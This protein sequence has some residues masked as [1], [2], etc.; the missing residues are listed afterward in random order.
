MASSQ[1]F[2]LFDDIATLLDDVA[3][4]T[5]VAT[6]K[7]AGVLGD[8][9][10]LNAQQVAGVAAKRELP[11]VWAVAKGSFLNKVIL[12]PS[13]LLISALVPAAITPL[14][15]IGGLFLCFEGA[16][17]ILHEFQSAKDKNQPQHVEVI[18]K[19]ETEKQLLAFEKEKIKGAI[20]TDFILSAEIV[21]IS[22]GVV[23]EKDFLQ[24]SLVLS[25]IAI[26]MTIG[27]YGLVALIVKL[28][29]IGFFL[30]KKSSPL[31]K[32][33]GIGLIRIAPKLMKSL[34][35]IGLIA[36]FLVGGGI[37]VHG[38]PILHH[39]VETAASFKTLIE[40]AMNFVVGIIAGFLV[41]G[42]I[43]IVQKL[44]TKKN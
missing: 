13:A 17:K 4:M 30:E 29:D 40:N 14:L 35:W 12:V 42:L 32:Y 27:V 38:I 19:I 24:K 6:K 5:K 44:K 20:R 1:F 11:V 41:L 26:A 15:I 7:T 43:S 22:L 18:K 37:L 39:I 23:A 8:D 21:V 2:A 25:T 28:D 10:A 3:A 33:S 36:M 34:S 9:L 31:L 16:E